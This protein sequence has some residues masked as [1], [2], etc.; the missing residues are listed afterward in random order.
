MSNVLQ[1]IIQL[2]D[3]DTSC[4]NLNATYGQKQYTT[5]LV[6]RIKELEGKL[7][8]EPTGSDVAEW[9]KQWQRAVEE[10][11]SVE[12]LGLARELIPMLL[13]K[14]AYYEDWNQNANRI[15]SEKL[16][17]V[18][19]KLRIEKNLNEKFSKQL[20]ELQ[21]TLLDNPEFV[22]LSL[23]LANAHAELDRLKK[24][25]DTNLS[26]EMGTVVVVVRSEAIPESFLGQYG[27]IAD[28]GEEKVWIEFNRRVG[29][30]GALL[31]AA[32]KSDVMRV[33]RLE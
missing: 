10:Q 24:E 21:R 33:G 8:E 13:G 11:F 3:T 26:Y 28:V 7:L 20:E 17:E 29:K 4:F 18:E 31:H 15:F 30:V 9:N 25:L 32:L 19:T 5:I 23:Q 22:S 1:T 2:F 12:Q 27:V 14:L 6:N 16:K